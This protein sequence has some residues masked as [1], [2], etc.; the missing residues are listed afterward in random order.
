MRGASPS[1]PTF[2][3]SEMLP[4]SSGAPARLA[5][6]RAGCDRR[7]LLLAGLGLLFASYLAA[8]HV[9]FRLDAAAPAR[10]SPLL[11]R[12]DA[13]AERRDAQEAL[14]RARLG[15]REQEE[16][17]EE[18]ELKHELKQEREQTANSTF[19]IN[20]ERKYVWI[21][22]A[23]DDQPAGRVTIEVSPRLSGVW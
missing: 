17:R 11:G 16:P 14:Q 2:T 21:D 13:Y 8:V 6:P 18:Q 19:P 10:Q 20:P 7:K 4:R 9:F 22:V 3:A 1:R 15:G 23:V 5:P 12:A